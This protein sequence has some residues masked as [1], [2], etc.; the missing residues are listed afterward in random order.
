MVAPAVDHADARKLLPGDFDANSSV[1]KSGPIAPP[2]SE[3]AGDTGPDDLQEGARSAPGRGPS[4]APAEAGRAR[5]ARRTGGREQAGVAGGEPPG[6][7][8]TGG[9]QK[10]LR[11]R[12]RG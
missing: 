12:A 7:P 5:C 9:L 10:S 2:Q 1:A 6:G 3:G 8:I 11:A 4:G